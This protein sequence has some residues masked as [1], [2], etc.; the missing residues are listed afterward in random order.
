[1]H[2]SKNNKLPK[3]WRILRLVNALSLD[4]LFGSLMCSIL[5]SRLLN[6][7]PGWAFWIVLP[8]A[9]W[10]IYTLDHLID[11]SR[12]K[13]K[14]S[15]FR[16]R[17]HFIHRK[18]LGII[19]IILVVST[20]IIIIYWLEK[21]IIIFG[22]GLSVFTT[23]YLSYL[24]FAGERSLKISKEIFVSLIYVCGIWG[25]QLAIVNY[26]MDIGQLLILIIFL[27]LVLADV[28]VLSYFEVD[29]DR[30]DHH[31]TIA[32]K[33][34]E[35][36]TSQIIVVLVFISFLLNIYLMVFASEHIHQIIAKLFMIMG[37]ILILLLSFPKFFRKNEIYRYIVECL[38]WIP[39]LMAIY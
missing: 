9:V 10:I 38:F 8:T 20:T 18:A 36:N 2:K 6:T 24:F 25:G 14:A 30:K 3:Q 29:S 33:Y 19:I 21:S 12:L 34:G 31:Q 5:I 22:I 15:T 1:M 7:T 13:A 39:G 32:V 26:K 16:H 35:K 11:A 17:F 23:L 37:M 27:L 28:L 4:V